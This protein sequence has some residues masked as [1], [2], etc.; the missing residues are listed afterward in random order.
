L[1]N[2]VAKRFKLEKSEV[3]GEVDVLVDSEIDC[4]SEFTIVHTE[5]VPELLVNSLASVPQYSLHRINEAGESEQVVLEESEVCESL[6]VT[7]DESIASSQGG[8][9]VELTQE[10]FKQEQEDEDIPH[11][12]TLQAHYALVDQKEPGEVRRTRRRTNVR[13]SSYNAWTYLNP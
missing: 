12:D 3:D 9:M 1:S 7:Q 4:G 2:P 13:L 6:S 8:L 11:E 5:S 10:A